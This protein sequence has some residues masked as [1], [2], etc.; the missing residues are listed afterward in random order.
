MDPSGSDWR[1]EVREDWKPSNEAH[2]RLLVS[3][4]LSRPYESVEPEDERFLK[5]L[6][7]ELDLVQWTLSVCLRHPLRC[8][9]RCPAPGEPLWAEVL[10]LEQGVNLFNLD[11]TS[12]RAL[13]LTNLQPVP[14]YGLFA[15]HLGYLC[16]NGETYSLR[17]PAAQRLSRK[18]IGTG[19]IEEE[20]KQPSHSLLHIGPS[21][22]SFRG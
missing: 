22:L 4:G 1:K 9:C 7:L 18:K 19:L 10:G 3:R 20:A 21:G 5:T 6:G 2:E 16:L 13:V 12:S 15:R 14:M 11:S 17:L 8:P